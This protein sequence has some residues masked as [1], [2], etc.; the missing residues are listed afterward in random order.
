MEQLTLDGIVCEVPPMPEEYMGNQTGWGGI[1]T[2]TPR[3]WTNEEIEWIGYLAG[4][5]YSKAQ[6]AESAEFYEDNG[7]GKGL[8]IYVKEDK[9]GGA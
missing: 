6:I 3:E 9:G 4:Q 5:G 1:T 2:T 8:F 7:Y